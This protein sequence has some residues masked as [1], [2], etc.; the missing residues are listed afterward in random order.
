MFFQS[1]ND[2]N[3]II[4]IYASQTTHFGTDYYTGPVGSVLNDERF[5]GWMVR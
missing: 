4:P 3:F 1:V 2:Y 5:V